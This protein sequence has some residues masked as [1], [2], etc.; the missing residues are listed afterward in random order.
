M[1]NI[2][3]C[4]KLA[5][6]QMRNDLY[7]SSGVITKVNNPPQSSHLIL[8]FLAKPEYVG[9]CL[10]PYFPDMV[11]LDFWLFSK[12]KDSLKESH[13]ES[14][15][16][17]MHNVMAELNIVHKDAFQKCFRLWNAL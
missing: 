15:D 1:Y 12:S 11:P 14:R 17:I 10:S 9:V 13:F 5:D 7:D 16:E 6:S 2:K 8:T 4:Q 3:F